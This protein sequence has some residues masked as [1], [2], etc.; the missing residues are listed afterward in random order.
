[1]SNSQ[2]FVLRKNW[3]FGLGIGLGIIPKTQKF[4]YPNSEPKAKIFMPK[5]KT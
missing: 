2:T 4:L 5:P 1:M 3:V